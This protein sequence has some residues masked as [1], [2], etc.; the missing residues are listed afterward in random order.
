MITGGSPSLV[1]G[2]TAPVDY[3]ALVRLLGAVGT[4]AKPFRATELI[5]MVQR[6]L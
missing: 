5:G 4:L 1:C 2:D 6:C 3:L